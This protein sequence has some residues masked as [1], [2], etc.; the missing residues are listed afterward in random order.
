MQNIK[1]S[2]IVI[3]KLGKG[4]YKVEQVIYYKLGQSLLQNVAGITKW[5]NFI[6]KRAGTTKQAS[7]WE[8]SQCIF[9]RLKQ[10]ETHVYW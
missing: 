4:Y 3:T 1:I 7:Y 2:P 9:V 10:I 5:R 8:Q 6:T